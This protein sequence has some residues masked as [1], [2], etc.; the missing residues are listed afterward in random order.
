[1]TESGK[2]E[3]TPYL[4]ATNILGLDHLTNTANFRRACTYI[5]PS[6]TLKIHSPLIPFSRVDRTRSETRI[7]RRQKGLAPLASLII[8]SGSAAHGS[9]LEEF[10]NRRR[11]P[12]SSCSRPSAA[13][14]TKPIAGSVICMAA[15]QSAM[16]VRVAGEEGSPMR[17]EG[18]SS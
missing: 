8:T 9:I 4:C 11:R 12:S 7:T 10:S 14:S 16:S 17:P 6:K 3:F 15:D 1:M 13:N 5:H 2:T 18:R